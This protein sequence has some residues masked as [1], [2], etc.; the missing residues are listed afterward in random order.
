MVEYQIVQY[1]ERRWTVYVHISPSNKYYV[2]ITSRNPTDRW[3][4]NGCN[5]RKQ[6]FNNAIKKYGWN[7]IQ[8]IIV[9]K[10]LTE[11][12]AKTME[13]CLIRELKSHISTHGY[14]VTQGGEGFLGFK[15]FGK[16]NSF[17]GKH[18]TDETKKLMKE[19]HYVCTG[20]NNSF[21]GKHHTE[22]ARRK[23]SEKA[24]ER[25]KT[26]P[27]SFKGKCLTE[28]RKKQIGIEHSRPIY[29][30]DLEM[31]FIR[32]YPNCVQLVKDGYRQASIRDVCKG[33]RSNYKGFVWRYKDEVEKEECA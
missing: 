7:N 32:E 28:E 6:V 16:D 3:G 4:L 19:R 31:N 10:N 22:E 9:S 15:R 24:K 20:K 18:H 33:K 5:Y 21:Y 27:S 26:N 17:Y 8:H 2:G 14:N 11:K 29:Q 30:Y 12:Q 25:Y 1:E 23:I 13:I